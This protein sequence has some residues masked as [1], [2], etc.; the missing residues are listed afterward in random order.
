MA[1][2]WTA[3]P[4]LTVTA[5]MVR[6]KKTKG[7]SVVVSAVLLLTALQVESVSASNAWWLTG[8]YRNAYPTTQECARVLNG[9]FGSVW[10]TQNVAYVDWGGSCNVQHTLDACWLQARSVSTSNGVPTGYGPQTCNGSGTAMAQSN[11]TIL[12]GDNG[13]TSQL[14]YWDMNNSTFI[15]GTAG[16]H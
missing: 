1:T 6:A 14:W 15:Y 8:H 10:Y 2:S 12:G 13:V 16:G 7:W 3:Y 9:A 4:S 5:E 11:A